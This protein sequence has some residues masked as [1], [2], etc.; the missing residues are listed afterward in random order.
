MPYGPHKRVAARANSDGRQTGLGHRNRVVPLRTTSVLCR[1][2]R[3]L[4]DVL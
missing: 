3:G 2:V 1:C 4:D